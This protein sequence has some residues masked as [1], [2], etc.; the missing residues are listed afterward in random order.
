MLVF[1]DESGDTGYKFERNSSPYFVVTMVLFGN[2][3]EAAKVRQS[4][5][6]LRAELGKTAMEFHFTNTNDRTRRSFLEAVGKH[7]FQVCAVVC[8]K[9][10]MPTLKE[11]HDSFLLEAF[12]AVM[13]HARDK[14]LLHAANVKYDEAGGNAFQKKLSSALLTKVNGMD[15]GKHIKQCE[16]QGSKG[17]DLIQLVDMIC[18]AVARPYNKPQ[19]KEGDYLETIKHRMHPVLEW[20]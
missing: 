10:R 20:P 14:G 4:I 1:V 15:R 11:K 8:D 17:N 13:E 2:E 19:R 16:P 5:D 7:D 18:G 9:K 3:E 6:D 12:S